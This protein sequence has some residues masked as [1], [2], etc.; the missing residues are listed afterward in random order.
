M[1]VHNLDVAAQTL[2]YGVRMRT[3]QGGRRALT[4]FSERA[5]SYPPE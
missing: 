2:M 5:L 4:D 3:I 1:D